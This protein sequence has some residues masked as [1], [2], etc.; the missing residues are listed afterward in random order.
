MLGHSENFWY[1]PKQRGLELMIFLEFLA[2]NF[3][4]SKTEISPRKINQMHYNSKGKKSF[5]SIAP[6][7]ILQAQKVLSV[8]N[9][10]FLI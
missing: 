8:R 9:F 2:Q 10:S 1:H 5:L 6:I 4:V 3:L 7:E